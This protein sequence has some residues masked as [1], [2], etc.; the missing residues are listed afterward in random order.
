MVPCNSRCANENAWRFSHR[1]MF[2]SQHLMFRSC[3]S[4]IVWFKFQIIS[5]WQV[6]VWTATSQRGTFPSIVL[7]EDTS[8]RGKNQKRCE[9]IAKEISA[10]ANY[11]M[12]QS[13]LDFCSCFYHDN[14]TVRIV[15]IQ[16]KVWLKRKQPK[17]L[18][19]L[20][21]AF[22]ALSIWVRTSFLF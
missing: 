9:E 20:T 11:S 14:P 18:S 2:I 21:F 15:Y 19:K 12:D 4:E 1:K 22:S 5:S 7:R 17:Y 13:F 8:I 6:P 10:A 3:L 16:K